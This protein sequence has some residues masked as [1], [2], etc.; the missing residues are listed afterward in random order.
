MIKY[1]ISLD[2]FDSNCTCPAWNYGRMCKH[3]DAVFKTNIHRKDR[4]LVIKSGKNWIGGNFLG[5]FV[6]ESPADVMNA[7]GEVSRVES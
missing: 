4:P 2:S 6:G 3:V 5:A 7:I 1:R